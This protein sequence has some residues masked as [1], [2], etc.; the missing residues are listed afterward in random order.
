[1]KSLFT[2]QVVQAILAFDEDTLDEMG[3]QHPQIRVVQGD[4]VNEDNLR[5][6]SREEG[7]TRQSSRGET[8]GS[9]RLSRQRN[10]AE[11]LRRDRRDERRESKEG[12]GGVGSRPAIRPATEE[13]RGARGGSGDGS[14]VPTGRGGGV[15]IV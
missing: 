4:V 12:R 8:T 1:M 2:Q 7:G 13:Q 14:G 15:Y 3:Y 6:L 5:R 11:D 9:V 10:R